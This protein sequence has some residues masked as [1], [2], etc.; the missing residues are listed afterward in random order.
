MCRGG[1]VY[2]Y[3]LY[4]RPRVR[5]SQTFN[6]EKEDEEVPERIWIWT[7]LWELW[8]GEKSKKK[9]KKT[10]LPSAGY[11]KHIYFMSES[12]H[13]RNKNQRFIPGCDFKV[14]MGRVTLSEIA[15]I[16]MQHWQNIMF[17]GDFNLQVDNG[18]I[19]E[20][21]ECRIS[22]FLTKIA[23]PSWVMSRVRNQYHFIDVDSLTIRFLQGE[24]HL[25]SVSYD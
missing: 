9:R 18:G 17:M 22:V 1:N 4:I 21:T 2:E 19:S 24:F 23:L 11:V 5:L 6:G 12:S 10:S 13:V 15:K 3:N 14:K 7:R 8:G 16:E 20:A 25:R